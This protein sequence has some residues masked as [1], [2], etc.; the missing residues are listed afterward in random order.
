[1]LTLGSKTYTY[2]DLRNHMEMARQWTV[3][4]P[5]A[6]NM[7]LE[8]MGQFVEMMSAVNQ[9]M[10]DQKMAIVGEGRQVILQSAYQSRMDRL[11][12]AVAL[13]TTSKQMQSRKTTS[14]AARQK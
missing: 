2:N 1:M 8:S 12:D 10:I 4:V 9:A 7:D 14:A 5:R 11:S 3:E 6:R 13:A